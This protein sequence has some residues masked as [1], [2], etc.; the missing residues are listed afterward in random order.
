[1]KKLDLVRTTVSLPRIRFV[2]YGQFQLPLRSE[3]G[4]NHYTI[5]E[6]EP[7]IMRVQKPTPEQKSILNVPVR[8][9]VG[10]IYIINNIRVSPRLSFL[11]VHDH[12]LVVKYST[13]YLNCI[14]IMNSIIKLQ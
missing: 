14:Q 11:P 2:Y 6:R 4:E 7:I 1:M 8:P 3:I 5:T 12:W 10:Y 13:N 9:E